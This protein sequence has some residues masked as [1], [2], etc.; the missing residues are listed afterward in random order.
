MNIFYLF[1]K[2]N[3][4]NQI[5]Y[6]KELQDKKI[7]HYKYIVFINMIIILLIMLYVIYKTFFVPYNNMTHDLSRLIYRN[8]IIH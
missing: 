6:Y 3:Y 7:K 1:S 2:N 4:M 5:I 8:Q